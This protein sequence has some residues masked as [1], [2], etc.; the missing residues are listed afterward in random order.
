MNMFAVGNR[1]SW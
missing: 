1:K